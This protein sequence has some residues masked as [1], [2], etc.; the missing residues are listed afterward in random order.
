MT[1]LYINRRKIGI[2]ILATITS[3][4]KNNTHP[5]K[6]KRGPGKEMKESIHTAFK[7]KK[8]PIAY[9]QKKKLQPEIG[10]EII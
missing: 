1:S 6:K 7:K 4:I 8:K 5:T 9:K 10:L 2:N 3:I